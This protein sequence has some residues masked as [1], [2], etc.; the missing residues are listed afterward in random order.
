MCALGS[1]PARV[2]GVVAGLILALLGVVLGVAGGVVKMLG[3]VSGTA[4]GMCTGMPG[5][6]GKGADALTPWL[7]ERLQSMAGRAG[8]KVLT[9]GDLAAG[10]IELRTTTTNLRRQPMAMPWTTQEYFF[11]PAGMRQLFPEDIVKWMEEHPPA[12]PPDGKPAARQIGQPFAD[13][14]VARG[15]AMT[16][17]PPH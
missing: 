3:G 9:F 16:D 6:G 17:P 1:G 15:A 5:A 14:E 4:F 7:H 12:A 8:G 10:R 11:E 2:A 13:P